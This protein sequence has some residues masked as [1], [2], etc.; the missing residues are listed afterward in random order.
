M[1]QFVMLKITL[2]NQFSVFWGEKQIDG[3]SSR[4]AGATFAYLA[5]HPHQP[6]ARGML[7]DLLY[8]NLPERQ[9]RQNFRKMVSR[10]RNAFAGEGLP[11]CE[12]I[13]DIQDDY[14]TFAPQVAYEVDVL[15]FE[16]LWQ[17]AQTADMAQVERSRHVAQLLRQ[18][19]RWYTGN[20]LPTA[21]SDTSQFGAWAFMIDERLS[22]L[23]PRLARL[24]TAHTIGA[25]MV[26]DFPI[27]ERVFQTMIALAALGQRSSN[28]N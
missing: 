10:L 20:F 19:V 16:S 13:L 22:Q 9:A 17:M 2:L 11:A 8:S 14:I 21:M 7:T 6:Q 12:Q 28:S 3:F 5:M 4:T 23:A 26:G 27:W 15:K 18:A 25:D 1:R 24:A